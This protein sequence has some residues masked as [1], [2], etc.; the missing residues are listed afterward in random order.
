MDMMKELLKKKKDGVEMDPKEKSAKM[1]MLKHIKGMAEG[2]MGDDIKGLKKVTVA[3]D[4]KEGLETGLKKASD[5]VEGSGSV[6]PESG[7]ED[8]MVDELGESKEGEME[9][10][11]AEMDS[12][13]EIDEMIKLLQEKKAKLV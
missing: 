10:V 2:A 6:M 13:E 9:E 3:S 4:S 7:K 8:N 1:D 5:I 11:L 12:P